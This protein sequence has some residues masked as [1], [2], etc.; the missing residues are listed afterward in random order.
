MLCCGF[1]KTSLGLENPLG[2]FLGLKKAHG[3]WDSRKLMVTVY[4]KKRILIKIGKEK[5]HTR[6]KLP[7]V[8][9][10]WSYT[11]TYLIL[12]AM[13]CDNTCEVSA[14]TWIK[15]YPSLCVQ[16]LFKV[17]H[18]RIWWLCDWLQLLPIL[19]SSSPPIHWP[20]EAS[21]KLLG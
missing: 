17:S 3:T 19:S 4:Y 21:S 6:S 15:S 12:R 13:V 5:R 9:F 16:F 18:L 7:G 10:Q 2:W 8:P 14:L 20:K 11:G 1:F